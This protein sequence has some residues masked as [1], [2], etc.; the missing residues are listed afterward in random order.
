M[1][2]WIRLFEDTE[3]C[4]DRVLNIDEAR[5]QT[6]FQDRAK[7]LKSFQGAGKR[8][9][10]LGNQTHDILTEL[11][12]LEPQIQGW[13]SEGIVKVNATEKIGER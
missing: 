13:I 4:L 11:G 5:R 1:S 7:Y 2:D 3:V 9:P 6:H 8:A 12:F 10:D